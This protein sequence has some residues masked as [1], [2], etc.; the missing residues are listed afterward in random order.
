MTNSEKDRFGV[1]M[2][3]SDLDILSLRCLQAIKFEINR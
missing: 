3:S 1:K 2:M